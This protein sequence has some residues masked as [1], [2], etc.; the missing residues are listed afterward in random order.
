MEPGSD[1]RDFIH[2]E[3][4]IRANRKAYRG[5]APSEKIFSKPRG[6]EFS[7]KRFQFAFFRTPIGIRV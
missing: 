3:G 4:V 7:E 2:P 1:D 6:R 5:A